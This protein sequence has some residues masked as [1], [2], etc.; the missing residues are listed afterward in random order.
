MLGGESENEEV[1]THVERHSLFVSLTSSLSTYTFDVST[2][3]VAQ[4]YIQDRVAEKEA[5]NT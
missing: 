3:Q 4:A 5:I 1:Q 2:G